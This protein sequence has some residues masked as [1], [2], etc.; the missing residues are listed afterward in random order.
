[1]YL[2]KRLGKYRNSEQQFNTCSAVSCIYW[3]FDVIISSAVFFHNACERT[4]PDFTLEYGKNVRA[5]LLTLSF[6]KKRK[7]NSY[8]DRSVARFV[9]GKGS[10]KP[11]W[12]KKPLSSITNTI[13]TLWPNR[14]KSDQ[15]NPEPTPHLPPVGSVIPGATTRTHTH[16]HTQ[17]H[18]RVT[19]TGPPRQTGWEGRTQ[20]QGCREKRKGLCKTGCWARNMEWLIYQGKLCLCNVC[21]QVAISSLS[22]CSQWFAN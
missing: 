2:K 13:Y 20:R 15:K 7:K 18:M 8:L 11:V 21:E 16:A 14:T 5:A 17:A 19:E 3:T 9:V 1:M 4:C 12:A 22:H 6:M 10:W